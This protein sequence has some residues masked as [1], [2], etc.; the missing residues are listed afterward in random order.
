MFEAIRRLM[1]NGNEIPDYPNVYY[2]V[3][4]EEISKSETRLGYQLP[5]QLKTFHREIGYAFFTSASPQT[6]AGIFNHINRFLAPSQI[7][8][9]LLND[10]EETRPSEGFNH[11]E[12][13]FFEVGDQLYLVLCPISS[14]SAHVCW[15]YGH[16]ISDSLLEFTE[17]LAS[18]PRFYHGV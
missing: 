14:Q 12:I 18:N 13:P 16:K 15:P 3:S 5:E 1:V 6:F 8:D 9:L 4:E 7:A 2:P 17:R 11:G 10:D